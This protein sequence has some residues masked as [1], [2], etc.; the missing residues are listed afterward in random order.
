MPDRSLPE[1]RL[2]ERLLREPEPP[3]FRQPS[4]SATPG[5]S[6]EQGNPRSTASGA[7]LTPTAEPILGPATGP[8]ATI[9]RQTPAAPA[10]EQPLSHAA[11]T[12]AILA[13]I[14]QGGDVRDLDPSLRKLAQLALHKQTQT[15]LTIG[16]LGPS[17]SGKSFALGRLIDQIAALARAAGTAAHTPFTKNV[18]AIKVD[19][20]HFSRDTASSIANALHEALTR[21]CPALAGEALLATRDPRAALREASDQ[22]AVA[23]KHLEN[24]RRTLEEA[25]SRR[26][27]LTETVL[28]DTPGSLLENYIR[29]RRGSIER[30]LSRFGVNGDLLRAYKDMVREAADANG[31]GSQFNS[32]LHAFWSQP[33]QSGR[34]G[35]AAVLLL[36][37]WGI[38]AA[39]DRQGFWL[40]GLRAEQGTAGIAAWLVDHMSW[41]GLAQKISLAGAGLFI[42]LNIWHG[43]RYLTLVGHGRRLLEQDLRERRQDIEQFLAHQT[44]QVDRLANEVE[45]LSRRVNETEK[46]AG[47]RGT[48]HFD[49]ATQAFI[50]DQATQSG[51]RTSA[52][53]SA[54]SRILDGRAT[55][56]PP[57]GAPE[58][59]LLFIDHFDALPP[60]EARASL[61]LLHRFLS[62]HFLLVVAF[63]PAIF[64]AEKDDM[65]DRLVQIPFQPGAAS[66]LDYTHYIHKLVGRASETAPA[67]DAVPLPLDPSHCVLETPF[68]DHEV[69]WIA[70]LAP[71]AGSSPR[72]VKRFVNLYRLLRHGMAEGSD[73]DAG[74]ALLALLLAVETGGT[75]EE[76]SCLARALDTE[77]ASGE[78]E[79]APLQLPQPSP[80]LAQAL[81]SLATEGIALG[82]GKAR[83]LYA[84]TR[85]F[86]LHG[87]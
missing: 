66:S 30:S 25:D 76:R 83:G 18:L 73:G 53:F 57:P 42:L 13:D 8:V 28:Y 41:F 68:T 24:E 7:T 74:N 34:L 37:S 59:I 44:L 81:A 54:I 62:P 29:R 52:F 35:W 22:L 21:A 50:D 6:P 60:A 75:A 39:I 43:W 64:G 79:T 1:H 19:A 14:A 12:H 26:A 84:I 85:L 71:L 10:K 82:L 3:A 80:R 65:L 77:P 61:A 4:G 87:L 67:L 23:R 16:L 27:R 58:R 33:G 2:S 31:I 36:L 38:G 70:A 78:A 63:D 47:L 17:G 9:P 32:V 20:S 72:A 55:P 51:A 40:G 69:R 49:T 15:P 56:L 11:I 86:S 46:R 48:D 45:T 5:G